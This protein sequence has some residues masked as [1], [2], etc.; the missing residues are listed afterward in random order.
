MRKRGSIRK[1]KSTIG[2]TR[3]YY[4]DDSSDA[5][6][7]FSD[8][9]FSLGGYSVATVLSNTSV[10]ILSA[11]DLVVDSVVD[12]LVPEDGALHQTLKKRLEPLD[13]GA[14]KSRSLQDIDV[15]PMKRRMS[16]KRFFHRNKDVASTKGKLKHSKSCESLSRQERIPT[17]LRRQQSWLGHHRYQ[18]RAASEKY[19]SAAIAGNYNS[20][21][22]PHSDGVEVTLHDSI[23]EKASIS[24][25][26]SFRRQQSKTNMAVHIPIPPNQRKSD[27]EGVIIRKSGKLLRRCKAKHDDETQSSTNTEL[28]ESVAKDSLS[29]Y[30]DGRSATCH[31]PSLRNSKYS[32]TEEA[33]LSPACMPQPKHQSRWRSRSFPFKHKSKL[34]KSKSELELVSSHDQC[35]VTLIKES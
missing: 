13:R 19:C 14:R 18:G 23:E 29:E 25:S 28:E 12:S 1:K 10:S 21:I 2:D 15:I 11:L 32:D 34:I 6:S 27:N 3:N 8:D 26:L 22:I 16:F 17:P 4:N 33:L 35:E 7:I 20:Q 9:N 5:S 31:H 24:R 30:R